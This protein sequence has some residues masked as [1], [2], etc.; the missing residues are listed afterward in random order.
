MKITLEHIQEDE[1]RQP[2]R[3]PI[4]HFLLSRGGAIEVCEMRWL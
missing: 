3:T 2:E 1:N 4:E